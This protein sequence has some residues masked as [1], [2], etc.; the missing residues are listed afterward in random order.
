[1]S[2]TQVLLNKIAALRQRLE[3]VQGL[4]RD[5]GS[6]AAA[7]PVK[8]PLAAARVLHLEDQVKAGA[9]HDALL[10]CVLRQLPAADPAAGAEPILP[11]QLTARAGRLL[12]RGQELLHQLRSLAGHPALQGDDADSLPARYRETVAMTDAVLRTVQAFP[13]APS[14]QLRLCE[15]LEVILGVAAERLAGLTALA[16][17][18]HRQAGW[19]QSLGDLLTG[20]AAGKDLSIKP[21]VVLADALLNEAQQGAP[22]RFFQAIPVEPA[23]AVAAHSLNVAQVAAR[24]ARLDPDLR[25]RALDPILAA[26]VHDVGMLGVPAEIFTQAGPLTD[27]QRRAVEGHALAGAELALRLLPTG[28]WLAEAAAG[29]HERLDGTG[30]P[31]GL[32]DV[33]ISSLTRLIAVCDVYAALCAPRPHRP[34]AQTRTG[35]TDTLLLAEQGGLDRHHAERLLH[36]SFYPVGTV[37]E[38]ADGAVG[39]VIATHQGRRDLNTPAR[40]VLA[41]L[42]DAQRRPLPALRH[43]DLA[44]CEGHSIVRG[45][46][47]GEG[48]ELL[49]KRFPELV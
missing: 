47:A 43:V 35:L 23:R 26:L 8:A 7:L 46:P 18:R 30:Y 6:A 40:P 24:L 17:E 37:V 39:V 41:L 2:D 19:L 38:L 1:M 48:R 45:L 42:T 33:Q 22:L 20:L 21:Y 34:A 31:S 10:D 36:L 16:L 49:G 12:K 25:G 32:R 27:E 9:R 29:H 4:V 15:G 13:N 11:S 28:N 3:Q 5:V 44:E 14:A